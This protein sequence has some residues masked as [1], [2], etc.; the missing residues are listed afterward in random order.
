MVTTTFIIRISRVSIWLKSLLMYTIIKLDDVHFWAEQFFFKVF[1]IHE[2]LSAGDS[3]FSSVYTII[4]KALLPSYPEV[5]AT[6]C[7]DDFERMYHVAV[8][9]EKYGIDSDGYRDK[10]PIRTKLIHRLLHKMDSSSTSSLKIVVNNFKNSLQL[11]QKEV[12]GQLELYK[13][14][15]K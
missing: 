11:L 13:E 10:H 3:T 2:R 14:N 7:E 8:P 4:M 9:L 15:F 6:V 5:L 1:M 12:Y